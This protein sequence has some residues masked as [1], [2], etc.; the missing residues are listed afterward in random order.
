MYCYFPINCESGSFST[1]SRQKI[2]VVFFHTQV[3]IFAVKMKRKCE[4]MTQHLVIIQVG[5]P[6][7]LNVLPLLKALLLWC[8]PINDTV[9]PEWSDPPSASYSCPIAFPFPCKWQ[10]K[11]TTQPR[12]HQWPLWTLH[13]LPFVPSPP[14][15]PSEQSFDHQPCVRPAFLSWG[16]NLHYRDEL[17]YCVD[18]TAGLLQ[19][20]AGLSLDRGIMQW[21]GFRG[22]FTH[23]LKSISRDA[24]L[25]DFPLCSAEGPLTASPNISL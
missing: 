20:R 1:Q 3:W 25:V 9:A 16:A 5:L 11:A 17:P 7:F 13:P 24:L 18:S 2:K 4:T 14:P 15:P 22:H 21:P 8:S 23:C 12:W 10:T 6:V 19:E